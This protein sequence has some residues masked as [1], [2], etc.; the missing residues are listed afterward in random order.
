LSVLEAGAAIFGNVY[1]VFE[2]EMGKM[3]K[4]KDMQRKLM[5]KL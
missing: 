4:K 1:G 2:K 3:K 5:L